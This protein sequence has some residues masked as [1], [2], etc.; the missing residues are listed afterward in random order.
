MKTLAVAI[1][2]TLTLQTKLAWF[3]WPNH[4]IIATMLIVGGAS[5]LINIGSLLPSRKKEPT[6]ADGKQP[7]P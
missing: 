2:A 4:P 5:A 1:V 7:I 6:V 3:V